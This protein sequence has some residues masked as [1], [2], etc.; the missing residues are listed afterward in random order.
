MKIFL[1]LRIIYKQG[2]GWIL[3]WIGNVVNSKTDIQYTPLIM[4]V[5][6]FLFFIF[7]HC[8]LMGTF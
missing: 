3:Q 1:H 7:G 5:F 4:C 2:F 6:S 8:T